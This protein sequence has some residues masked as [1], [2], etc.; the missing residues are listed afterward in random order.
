MIVEKITTYELNSDIPKLAI[1]FKDTD[2]ADK[3]VSNWNRLV[4][5]GS[6]ARKPVRPNNLNT[7]INCAKICAQE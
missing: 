2:T 3:V 6:T 5:G 1:Q 7:G 4:C